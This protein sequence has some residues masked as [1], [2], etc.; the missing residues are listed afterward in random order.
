M[1]ALRFVG[2]RLA[3]AALVVFLVTTATFVLN[4]ALPSDPARMVAGAQA[5]PSDVA[6]IRKQLG[7]DRSIAEQY[8]IF[9]QR[10]VHLGPRE[11]D[12]RSTSEH[13]SCGHLGALHVDLGR[14]YQQRRPVV[15]IIADRLPRTVVL[16][17]AAVTISVLL[18]VGSGLLAALRR[19]TWLDTTTVAIAL[20][21]ISAPTF[22]LGVALQWLL[23]YQLR[24]LPLSGAGEGFVDG[25]RHLAL[26]ALTLGVFGA[27]YYTR[28]VRG[29]MIELLEAD[30]VRTARAKGVAGWRVVLVH[31]L[32]NAL[33][34]IV[35]VVGLELGA[36]LGGAVITEQIFS[37]PGIGSLAVRAMRDRDGPVIVGTVL[38]GA[39]AI[40]LA[41]LVVDLLY[42][43][44]DPRIR[45]R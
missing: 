9:L 1:N 27:A 21:G 36:L 29:E 4:R 19:N 16:A 45:A 23:A 43:L 12:V 40:V 18:G 37:W 2:R 10:L 20:L 38:V 8:G 28:L 22:V 17:L 33:V 26:P 44:L 11:P 14:S 3:W 7:L 35:T 41:S 5:R 25:L 31:G 42:A 13:A 39:V 34:P 24:W 15:T 6:K 30:Y 32:R